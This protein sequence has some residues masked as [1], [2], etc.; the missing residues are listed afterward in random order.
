MKRLCIIAP[1][2]IDRRSCLVA[3]AG[4][5]AAAYLAIPTSPLAG[6]QVRVRDGQMVRLKLHN[7]LTTEN[8]EKGDLIEFDVAEDVVVAERVVIAKGAQARGRVIRVKGAGKKKAK[9]A[10]VTFQFMSV[11]AVDNQE[12]PIRATANKPKKKGESRENEVDAREIIPGQVGRV[13]GA[14]KGTEYAAYTS[15]AFVNAPETASVPAAT[16]AGP[17]SAQPQTQAGPAPAIPEQEPAAIDFTSEPAG[18]D[19]NIDGSF[20]GTTPSSLRVP[21]GRHAIEIRLAGY[22]VWTRAMVVDPGSHPTIRVT[23]EKQ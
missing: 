21:A 10:C 13:I 8:V 23:L 20:K 17:A 14:D 22:R 2:G 5:A 11:R 9:D 4:L 6:A 15:A 18:A 7:L 1:R 19:I 12:I 3:L 16:P